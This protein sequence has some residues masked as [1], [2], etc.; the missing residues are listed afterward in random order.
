VII[1]LLGFG[2]S[3]RPPDF[4][5]TL[6]DHAAAVAAVLDA[7]GV[8]GVVVVGHSL[9]GSIGIRLAAARPELVGS[10]LLAEANLEPGPEEGS[11]AVFSRM[12]AAHS[13]EAWCH[14]KHAALLD[15]MADEAPGVA[16]RLRLADPRVLHRTARSL[17]APGRPTLGEQLLAL[18]LPRTYVFGERSLE[19]SDMAERA[20]RLG[21]TE[22]AVAVVPG[23]GHDMGLDVR[24]EGFA[25][26]VAASL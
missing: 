1:D 17:T 24:P 2:Y 7:G 3:D 11:N 10:L 15:R 20:D 25:S 4:A 6:D 16:A 19:H 23:V 13:E 18:D 26:I 12:I 9:G 14:E 22:V 21:T 5:A 8:Q